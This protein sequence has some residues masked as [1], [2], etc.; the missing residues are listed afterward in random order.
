MQNYFFKV[1]HKS[2]FCCKAKFLN[3]PKFL[4][5]SKNNIDYKE[6]W[7]KQ[8]CNDLVDCDLVVWDELSCSNMTDY[9]HQL[10]YNLLDSRISSGKSNIITGN[11]PPEDCEE[12]FGKRLS[13]RIFND[14]IIEFKGRDRRGDK[15]GTA[16]D[17]E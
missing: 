8:L 16:T 11:L 10:I 9:E 6:D 7:Y 3:V 5:D 12:K 1:W 4:V 2:A 14:Q 13:S 17:F 15:Y